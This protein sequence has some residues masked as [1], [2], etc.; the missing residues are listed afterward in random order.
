MNSRQWKGVLPGLSV[1]LSEIDKN[2]SPL[3]FLWTKTTMLF[4]ADL[5]GLMA[6]TSSMWLR[7]SFTSSRRQEGMFLGLSLKG[8]GSV[9]SILCSA[10]LQTAFSSF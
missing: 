6:P 7:C 9:T 4:Q 2:L 10:A 5:L 1:Q 3:S 8:L